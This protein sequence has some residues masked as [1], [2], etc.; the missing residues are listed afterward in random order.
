MITHFN[1]LM[2]SELKKILQVTNGKLTWCQ[3]EANNDCFNPVMIRIFSF[4]KRWNTPFNS[5]LL[6]LN[7]TFHLSPNENFLTIVFMNIHYLHNFTVHNVCV[8]TREVNP[9]T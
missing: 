7:E 9:G 1:Y 8:Q 5:A 6:E 3:Y 4:R 2:G